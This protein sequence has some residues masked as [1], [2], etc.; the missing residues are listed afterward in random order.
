MSSWQN[1]AAVMVGGAVGAAARMALSGGVANYFGATFPWGTLIV[2]VTGC[3]L[4]GFFAA[5]SGPD[6][7]VLISPLVRQTVMIGILGGY[8]TF[9]S[10]S[11]QTLE[12]AANGEWLAALGNLAGTVV[13]CLL[14]T[15]AGLA[16]PGL[17]IHRSS[18]P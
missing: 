12:L 4:I 15:T 9:S 2:N 18:L 8:T 7:P 14:A 16:L 3:F 1:Y 17:L 11:L 6:S 10:F 13:A 5:I